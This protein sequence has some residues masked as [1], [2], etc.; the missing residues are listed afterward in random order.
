MHLLLQAVRFSTSLAICA[1]LLPSVFAEPVAASV[2]LTRSGAQLTT[3]LPQCSVRI[4]LFLLV[5][6]GAIWC[7]CR[8]PLTRGTI[9]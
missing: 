9:P 4:D 6:W 7:V 1:A 5:V 3:L 8:R 2:G